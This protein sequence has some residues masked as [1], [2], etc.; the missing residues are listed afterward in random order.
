[1]KA[2]I[3]VL[4]GAWLLAPAISYAGV[5]AFPAQAA[6]P[7]PSYDSAHRYAQWQV[8]TKRLAHSH[9]RSSLNSTRGALSQDTFGRYA[10]WE[11][12]CRA[13][14]AYQRATQR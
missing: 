3:L 7:A 12:E 10:R 14:K 5:K 1:M 4:V 11:K 9:P 2:C 8:L 13:V 6:A